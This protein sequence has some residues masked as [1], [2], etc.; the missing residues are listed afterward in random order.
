MKLWRVSDFVD[1]QG[2][3]GELVKARWHNAGQP[4]VYT[5]E[6]SALALLES[7]VH[8]ESEEEPPTYQLLELDVPDN[9]SVTAYPEALAPPGRE[10]SRAWGDA[11]LEAAA[12][13]LA[14]VPSII[15]PDARNY[16]INPAHPDA[17]RVSITRHKRYEWDPR[18]FLR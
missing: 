10:T 8:L 11:W 5:A 6:H 12:T 7:L 16:L 3:G 1:L 4:I 2:R 15:A 14:I 18:L 13:P 9:L 17:E